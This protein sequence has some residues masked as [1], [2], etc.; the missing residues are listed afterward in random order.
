MR[1]T[2]SP[3]AGFVRDTGSPAA[4]FLRDTANDTPSADDIKHMAER[5][6]N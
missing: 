5:N 4:R 6:D 3:A 2:G 1:D